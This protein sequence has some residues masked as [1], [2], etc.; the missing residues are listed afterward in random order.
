MAQKFQTFGQ[1]IQWALN[2]QLELI[3]RHSEQYGFATKADIWERY[4]CLIQ[5]ELPRKSDFTCISPDHLVLLTAF[6]LDLTQPYHLE[7]STD[8]MATQFLAYLEN[9]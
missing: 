3:N 9:H 8:E 1:A 5:E 7:M 2:T 6:L 4:S